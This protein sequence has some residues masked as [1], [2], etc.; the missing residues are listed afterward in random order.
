MEN[1]VRD[2]DSFP[3]K[4]QR[5]SIATNMEGLMGKCSENRKG[6]VEASVAVRAG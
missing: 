4:Q 2:Y 5:R 3:M 6:A 1:D